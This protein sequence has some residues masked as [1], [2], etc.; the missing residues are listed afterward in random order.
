MRWSDP[1]GSERAVDLRLKYPRVATS[2]GP[3]T[4]RVWEELP[5]ALCCA[6]IES[7]YSLI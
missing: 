6:L 1:I 4:Q 7:I 3:T 2:I 5:T